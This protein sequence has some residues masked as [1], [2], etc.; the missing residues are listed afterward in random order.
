MKKEIGALLVHDQAEHMRA[1]AAMLRHQDIRVH[2]VRTCQ[3]AALELE[4]ADPPQ[5]VFTDTHLLDGKW[6]DIVLLA[7]GASQPVN[8]IVVARF[9]DEKLYIEAL[10]EG[11]FDFIVPPFASV[12]LAHVVRCAADNVLDRRAAALH[13]LPVSTQ[14]LI[15]PVPPQSGGERSRV[16]AKTSDLLP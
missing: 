7:E 2:H 11:A 8:V 12:D 3:V 16:S 10:E 5:L 15:A 14:P 1:L 9:M 4:H 13:G 6:L